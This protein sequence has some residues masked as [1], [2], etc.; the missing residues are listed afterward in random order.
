MKRVRNSGWSAGIGLAT[1]L[2]VLSMTTVLAQSPPNPLLDPGADSMRKQ[3]PPVFTAKFETSKGDVIIEVHRD[4]APQG[5]DRFYNLVANGYYNDCRFFRVLSNFMA[6]TGLHADPAVTTA[7]RSANI[8]DDPVKRSNTR[9]YVTYAQSAAPNS[10][11]TQIFINYKD[12]SFLDQQ[13]FAPFGQVVQ[14]MEVVDAL[15]AAYGEGPPRGSGPDQMKIMMQGNA[16]LTQNFPKLDFIKTCSILSE[17]PF[18]AQ[19]K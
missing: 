2:A 3:A 19:K 4:W 7:W 12:N 8:L 10:R 9:G 13:R 6:Q 15:Y 16:Y 1:L 17:G 11:T 5:A 14:G 18:E